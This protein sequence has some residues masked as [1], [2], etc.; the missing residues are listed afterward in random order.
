MN[1]SKFTL[2]DLLTII[3]AGVYSAFCF[4]SFNFISLGNKNSSLFW[5]AFIF[6]IL[7]GLA[8]GA[9]LLKRS[10]VNF[11]ASIIGEW[12]LLL[13]FVCASFLFV[14]SFSHFFGVTAKK[15]AIRTD[16]KASVVGAEQLFV[17]Y[18]KYADNR[19]LVYKNRLESVAAAKEINPT[20]YRA[21]GFW[22][23]ASD[24]IQIVNKLFILRSE[25]YPV[26]YE[27]KKKAKIDWLAEAQR[28]MADWKPI[29]I[30]DVVNSLE[31]N[32]NEWYAELAA[33][34]LFKAKGEE[35]VA[36]EHSL[37]T[38]AVSNQF[39]ELASPT[40]L[41]IVVA[42]ILYLLMLLSYLITRRHPRYPGFGVVFGGGGSRRNNGSPSDN[43][44]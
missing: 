13:L 38:Q 2:A 41:S 21:Y 17:E 4:L 25:L 43:E 40:P 12:I 1:Q 29:G 16:I 8:M 26:D 28:T 39:T 44:W 35:A 23:N 37:A 22:G 7:T 5:A 31:T 15:E 14:F 33:Y 24:S 9:K 18:E 27:E 19:L 34:S 10:S 42:C 36:F 11:R 3:F 30:V 6:V 32:I 20:E